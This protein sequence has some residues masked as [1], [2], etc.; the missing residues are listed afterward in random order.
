VHSQLDRHGPDWKK[1]R[2]S[3]SSSG[4]WPGILAE[5]AAFA[6]RDS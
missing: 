4:G 6:V 5:L 2:D 3:V 1:L